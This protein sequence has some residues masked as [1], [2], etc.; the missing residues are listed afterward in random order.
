MDCADRLD[1]MEQQLNRIEQKLDTLI[2][3]LAQGDDADDQPVVSLDDGRAFKAR[4]TD[5][6]LG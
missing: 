6:G 4:D 2:A 5:R 3:A 1:Q